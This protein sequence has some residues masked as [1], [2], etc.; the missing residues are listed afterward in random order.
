MRWRGIVG[1][2]VALVVLGLAEVLARAIWPVDVLLFDW[3][4]PDGLISVTPEG[5]VVSQPGQVATLRDGPYVWSVRLNA[6][7]L[8]ENHE[9]EGPPPPGTRRVLAL[10]DSWMFGFSVD[11]GHTLPDELERRLSGKWG[12]GA[13]EVVNA[14]VFGASAFD[15]L[16]RYRQLVELAATD[17]VLLAQPHNSAPLSTFA[18]ERTRWYRETGEGPASTWRLYLL[19]RRALA[20]LRSSRYAEPTEPDGQSAEVADLQWLARDAAARGL[21]VWFVEMPN[22]LAQATAGFAGSPRWREALAPLGVRFAGHALR[23]RACWGYEDLGH[24]SAAG[25]VAIAARVAE[26]IL[27]DTSTP[28]GSTPP[29]AP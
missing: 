20:P 4:R 22:N 18:A 11:Q 1:G 21:S 14:G 6:M 7:G 8:R 29:C 3:E 19:A 12:T 25:T 13:V 24:P 27:S 2:V 26:T 28:M 9:I 23:E 10:G 17:G 16:R 15:M 5:G